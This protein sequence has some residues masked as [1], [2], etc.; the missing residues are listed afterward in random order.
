MTTWTVFI[1]FFLFSFLELGRYSVDAEKYDDND[2][3]KLYVNKVGPYNNPHETYHYYSL[4]VCIP[5]KIEHR[6]L[7]LGEVL[8]GDR[9]AKSL[10]KL[11]FKMDLEKKT[12]CTLNLKK[13]ELEKLSEAIED[14]YYFEFV[15]DDLPL[16]NFVGHLEEGRLFPHTHKIMVW[17]QYDFVFE[18]NDRQ[19]IS[20]NVSVS[21]GV[22]LPE[23]P[24][25][26]L[27]ITHTYSAKWVPTSVKYEDRL[28]RFKARKFFP[29]TLEIHW[30]SV[31]NSMV[32]AFLL[33]SFVAV[34][35][36][37]IVKKDFARYSEDPAGIYVDEYGWKIIHSDVFRF[38][39]RKMLFCAILGVGS[40]LLCM[41]TIIIV[42][43]L[44]GQFSVHRHGAVNV[45]SCFLYALTSIVSGFVACRFF[46]QMGEGF[47]W[48]QCVHLTSCLFA[49]PFFVLWGIQNTVAWMYHS[50]QALP[51][52]TV[53]LM[54]MVWLFIGYPLT[55]LGGIFGKNA[56]GD[57]DAPCRAKNI[58][59]EIPYTPWYRSWI[60]HYLVGGFLPF[61]AISV[62]L[63][64][65]FATLWSREPYTLYGIL[66]L[67]FII[68][69]CVTATVSIALTYFQLAIEDHEWWWRSI[70]AAGST[71][72]FIFL[73][74][75]FYYFRRSNMSGFFQTVE[76]FSSIFI[77]C[78]AFFLALGTVA[79]FASLKFVRYIYGSIKMD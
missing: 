70:F 49:V 36:M 42:L 45:A 23:T 4:P 43:A 75:A 14:Q 30:L 35:L 20:A 7:S 74:A 29:I 38:P 9:M 73:Y 66:G 53:V 10:Y 64:Y 8:D 1:L 61:S 79:F 2:E 19:I 15:V 68:V 12:L 28:D 21:E 18:Y 71:S 5:E 33:I 55:V 56:A 44:A 77:T 37:R 16:R 62:E 67:T 24:E 57:F 46:K 69:L 39:Q 17:T 48:V 27:E 60:M 51:F 22:E 34:I 25:D 11:K 40:Q 26:D 78:Y 59:R 47:R 54:M 3:V 13:K 63:Y 58:P 76:F 72:V 31:M 6:S 41:A 50:T 52:T 32:L 65:V